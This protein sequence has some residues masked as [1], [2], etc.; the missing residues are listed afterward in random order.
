[1]A[2][3]IYSCAPVK[4]NS[5][6]LAADSLRVP[7]NV[8]AAAYRH[9]GNEFPSVMTAPGAAPRVRF[10]TPFYEAYNLIGLKGLRCTTVEV[11]LSKFSAGLKSSSTDHLK[12]NLTASCEGFAYLTGF[13][14]SQNGILMADVEVV[15]ISNNGTSHPLTAGTGSLPTLA[16]EPAL[17]T[18]GPSTINGTTVAGTSGFNVDLGASVQTM[19]SDGDLYPRACAYVGG[20]PVIT[21]EHADPATL[22]ATLTLNGV[23]LSSNFVQY[24][25]DYSTTT[26]LTQTTGISITVASGRVIPEDFGADNLAVATGSFRVLAM[27][28]S[29]TH[30]LVIATGA[31][32]P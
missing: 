17:R 18:S 21:V 25:R 10:R 26:G 28:T 23:A 12:Y 31:S 27:S 13:G 22:L 8:A 5:T 7:P 16:S 9:S 3:I 19:L 29:T 6:V 15:L 32:V 4:L 11:Y 20:D 2:A 24:A 14:C 30:P 1:M